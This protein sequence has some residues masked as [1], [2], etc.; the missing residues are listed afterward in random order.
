MNKTY[1]NRTSRV[2]HNFQLEKN[3]IMYIKLLHIGFEN[4]TV[5]FC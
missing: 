4:I 3:L 1:K 2:N 5:Y